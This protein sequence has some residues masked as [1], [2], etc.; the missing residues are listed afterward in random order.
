MLDLTVKIE[1]CD[2]L[3]LQDAVQ[4]VMNALNSNIDEGVHETVTHEKYS[5]SLEL[6]GATEDDLA[7]AE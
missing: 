1:G 3:D 2:W 7:K 6:R 4:D 5:Y